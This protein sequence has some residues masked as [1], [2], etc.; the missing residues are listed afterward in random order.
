MSSRDSRFTNFTCEISANEV[1]NLFHDEVCGAQRI[2]EADKATCS[3]Y[4]SVSYQNPVIDCCGRECTVFNAQLVAYMVVFGGVAG[5]ILLLMMS[6]CTCRPSKRT[7]DDAQ[8]ELFDP[9]AVGNIIEDLVENVDLTDGIDSGEEGVIA[10]YIVLYFCKK[11]Q[12]V[13]AER[14]RSVGYTFVCFRFLK[15]LGLKLI[16]AVPL[17]LRK[18]WTSAAFFV[19]DLFIFVWFAIKQKYFPSSLYNEVHVLITGKKFKKVLYYLC[20]NQTP[21][22]NGKELNSLFFSITRSRKLLPE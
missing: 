14:L 13:I 15:K 2:R 8:E 4:K 1:K 20:F 5:G 10:K 21:F 6:G 11:E 12:E 17:L 18:E 3:L 16:L 22:P 9:E 19:I 7:R